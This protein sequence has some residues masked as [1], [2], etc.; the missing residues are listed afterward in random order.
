MQVSPITVPQWDQIN[1]RYND[2]SSPGP[3]GFDHQDLLGMPLP[4][5]GGVVSLLTAI[6]QGAE[7]LMQLLQGFGICVPKHGHAQAISEFRPMIN[8]SQIYRS[9]GALRSRAILRHLGQFAPAG[10]KGFRP[11]REAGDIWPYVQM[12]VEL[13]LQQRQCLSG[14]ISDVKKAL[15]VCVTEPLILCRQL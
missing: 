10:V 12:L 6:E 4:C 13:S 7:W 9:W 15:R 3:D 5:K 1:G 8:L 11:Q 14:V 2:S